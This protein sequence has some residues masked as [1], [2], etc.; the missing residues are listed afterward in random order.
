MLR[1]RN[2]TKPC[3]IAGLVLGEVYMFATLLAPYRVG[4]PIKM[5]MP[6]EPP[7]PVIGNVVEPLWHL[8]VK[9]ASYAVMFGLFGALV[10]L[11][12]G[13]LLTGLLSARR[14]PQV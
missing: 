7:E 8:L 9:L 10:G 6:M 13:L 2:F 11:G 1:G 5:T 3:S 12:I 4:P 14:P